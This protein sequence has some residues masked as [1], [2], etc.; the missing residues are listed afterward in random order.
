MVTVLP[1][2]INK[3]QFLETLDIRRTNI[4]I[5]PAQVI[6]LPYLV[7]LLGKFKLTQGLG[8]RR[9][10]KLQTWL[11]E[12]SKL[13]MLAGFVG[14]KSQ[15][16]TQLMGHMEYLKKVKI[17]CESTANAS[18]NLSHLSEAIKGFIERGTDLTTSLSLSL[19]FSGERSQDL[20]SFSLENGNSYYLS[21]L[22]LQGNNLYSLPPF[23][24]MLAG[25]TNL[26]L[27]FPHHHLSSEIIDALSRVCGLEYLKL[28]ATQLDNLIIGQ[29]AFR[30]L[31]RLCVVVDVM[32]GLEI[33]GGALPRLDSLW[34][35]CK[36]LNGFSSTTIQSLPRLK[37]VTLYDG[38]SNETKLECKEAVKNHPRHP[39]LLFKLMGSKPAVGISTA[40]TTTYTIAQEDVVESEHAE[41]TAATTIDTIAQENFVESEPEENSERPTTPPS[42]T[43]LPMRMPPGAI[44]AEESLQVVTSKIRSEPAAETP[45]APSTDMT[46]SVTMPPG[47]IFT[48]EPIQIVISETGSGSVAE[49]SPVATT[50]DKVAQED[51]MGSELLENSENPAALP[52]DMVFSV[53]VTQGLVPTGESGEQVQ[54]VTSETGSE[55]VAEIPMNH[56]TIATAQQEYRVQVDGDGQH[57]GH[58]IQDIGN[59]HEPNDFASENGPSSN[60]ASFKK[61]VKGVAV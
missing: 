41:S 3:L 9:M 58:E 38:L 47:A 25:L 49:I 28:T 54:V 36:D 59:S 61:E 48:A 29:G 11:S 6:E 8:R 5:L 19:N 44:S 35:L 21:S 1:K 22:K 32:A 31:R 10:R 56:E 23:V 33:Q 2:E 14:D 15:E 24:T 37:E 30:S 27:S 43:T 17:W 7:H 26:C 53:A 55:R 20:L 45:V 57:D 13:E 34:L 18:S 4:E 40:P 16:L 50:T 51:A 39:K 52:T 42:D 12:N 60:I 46:L